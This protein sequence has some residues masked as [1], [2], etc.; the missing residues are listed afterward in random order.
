[1]IRRGSIT[2]EATA[3]GNVVIAVDA[4]AGGGEIEVDLDDAIRALCELRFAQDPAGYMG[5]MDTLIPESTPIAVEYT[6]R[7]VLERIAKP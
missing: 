7:D 1:M 5:F 6:V 4:A 3:G 2:V